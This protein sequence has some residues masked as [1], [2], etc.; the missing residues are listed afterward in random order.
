MVHRSYTIEIDS[1]ERDPIAYP[2]PNDYT[3]KLNRPIYD[4]TEITLV[5]ASI[6]KTQNLINSGNKQFDIKTSSGTITKVLQEGTWSV[7]SEFASN[8]QTQLSNFDGLGNSITVSYR[9]NTNSLTF[10][11]AGADFSFLFYSGSNGFSVSSEFGTPAT[12]FGFAHV[13]TP[14]TTSLVSNVIDLSGPTSLILSMSSGATE[15][16]RYLYTKDV[17]NKTSLNA[18]YTGRI[19][20]GSSAQSES[21][22]FFP[23]DKAITHHFYKG[24][25]KI[26]EYLT[27]KFY[28]SNGNK[29]IKYDFGKRN[30]I[31]KFEVDCSIDKFE[32]QERIDTTLDENIIDLPPPVEFINIKPSR[33]DFKQRTIFW[34][35]LIFLGAGLLALAGFSDRQR[36]PRPGV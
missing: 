30:H 5:S 1:N 6:P 17:E 32:I 35:L 9:S 7:G 20:W 27:I 33:Y 11:C 21:V 14:S 16:N 36:I 29:L 8:I 34:I 15:L 19:L 2:N 31:L 4:V 25:E 26:I 28:Y 23:A 22:D 13:D 10:A 12:V 24:H 3:V 18:F